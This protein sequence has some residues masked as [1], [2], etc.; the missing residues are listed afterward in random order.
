[1]PKKIFGKPVKE[2]QWKKAEA[3][4]EKQGKGGDYAYVMGIF[5]K[6]TGLTN[7][8]KEKWESKKK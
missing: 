1:M 7:K 8:I 3:I 4:A 5:K 2:S 6:M